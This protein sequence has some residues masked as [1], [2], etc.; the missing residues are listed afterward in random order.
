MIP[1]STKCH[2][3]GAGVKRARFGQFADEGKIWSL[4]PGNVVNPTTS[5]R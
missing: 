2:E 4:S 5:G 3:R 1:D